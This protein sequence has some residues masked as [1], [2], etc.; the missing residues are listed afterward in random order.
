[1]IDRFITN[2]QL[3]FTAIDTW[4]R[5]KITGN[6]MRSF[7]INCKDDL[8]G[9]TLMLKFRAMKDNGIFPKFLIFR[10]SSY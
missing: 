7:R 8:I 10:Y 4:S 3:I 9:E 5:N 1:M 2:K 6:G